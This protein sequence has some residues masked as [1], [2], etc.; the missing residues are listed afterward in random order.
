M[1]F[2]DTFDT[3][4]ERVDQWKKRECL[5]SAISKGKLYFLGDKK[6]WENESVHK[7]SNK[8]MNKACAQ[9]K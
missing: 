4:K 8:T 3:P 6:Q 5:I 2:P 9:Y 1:N 7:A